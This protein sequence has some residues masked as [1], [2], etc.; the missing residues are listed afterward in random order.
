MKSESADSTVE[1]GEPAPRGPDEGKR[2]TGSWTG[3]RT[4]GLDTGPAAVSTF[5][6]PNTIQSMFSPLGGH[7]GEASVRWSWFVG[8]SE[9]RI[10]VYSDGLGSSV[11]ATCRRIDTM[12]TTSP[13][14]PGRRSQKA[15]QRRPE[16]P[17]RSSSNLFAA[18][19][20]VSPEGP[21]RSGGPA[22]RVDTA[23][24]L[25]FPANNHP[26]RLTRPVP[27]HPGRLRRASDRP[28]SSAT[29]APAPDGSAR[30]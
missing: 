27:E 13:E 24:P 23:N 22:K 7:L 11:N 8:Q 20:A 12:S 14:R 2:R 15:G 16:A 29:I 3:A 25:A 4:D 21:Q 6:H 28:A 17:F 10:K 5:T 26:G 18:G 30:R 1:V 9:G 19:F